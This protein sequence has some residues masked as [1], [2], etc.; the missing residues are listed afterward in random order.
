MEIMKVQ[1]RMVTKNTVQNTKRMASPMI[2]I[3]I[4]ITS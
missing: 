1:S 3:A 4:S 2:K